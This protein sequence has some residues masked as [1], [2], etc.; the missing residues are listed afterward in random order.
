[1]K[2]QNQLMIRKAKPGTIRIKEM[3]SINQCAHGSDSAEG[4]KKR[5]R[6]HLE[7]EAVDG[8]V[9][10]PAGAGGRE[11]GRKV[12]CIHKMESA[13]GSRWRGMVPPH[14]AWDGTAAGEDGDGSTSE[15]SASDPAPAA[16]GDLISQR[17]TGEWTRGNGRRR[18]GIFLAKTN[19][20]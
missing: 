11:E 17:R 7:L 18:R 1:M 10:V 4:N 12:S 9:V 16:A 5:C 15:K 8:E 14:L 6:Y 19:N 20:S 2:S 3:K 13:S